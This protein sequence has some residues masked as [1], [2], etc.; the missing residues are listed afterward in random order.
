MMHR[1][2]SRVGL[3]PFTLAC[4]LALPFAAAAASGADFGNGSIVERGTFIRESMQALGVAV[5][6]RAPGEYRIPYE[7]IPAPMLPYIQAAEDAKALD[8]FGKDLRLAYPIT[9]GEALRFLVELLQV[10]SAQDV[11]RFRDVREGTMEERA[12][13]VAIGKA[14]MQPLRSNYFGLERQLTPAEARTLVNRASGEGGGGVPAGEE[15]EDASIPTI[16][17]ELRGKGAESTGNIPNAKVLDAVWQIVRS[18]YLYE[19]KIDEDDAMY[20]SIEAVVRSLGDPYSSFMRPKT[21]RQFQTQIDGEV[22]GIGAQVE[23]REGILTIVTPLEGSPAQKAGL[24]PNDQ[25]LSVDGV[26]IEDLDFLDAVE[27]VRGPRG[28]KVTLT[29]SR[30]GVHF[31]VT[32]LRDT[33]KVPEIAVS[34][35]GTVAVVRLMQFGKLTDTELRGLLTDIQ[36]KRPTGIVLDLRNNP[37]GLLHAANTVVSNF[38]PK[39]SDVAIIRARDGESVDRTSEEPTIRTDVPLVVLVNEG[40]ASASEIVAGALQDHD[41]ATIVGTKSFGKGTVQEV[42]EFVD[43]SSLKLTIAEWFTPKDRK[44][45]GIGVEPDVEVRYDPDRDVQLLRAIDLLR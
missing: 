27:K 22:S 9:R 18:D 29:I 23:E 15:G 41:R 7:R 39:G 25:I 14:W 11:G 16:R 6:E 1:F 28:S 34:W 4:M 19:E 30:N 36:A 8:A 45:D 33:V 32:V 35:Q 2:L 3:L 12:V 44:I 24:K 38:L 5:V 21:S 37:G 13:Q 42:L 10:K 20:D 40:S 26:S 43:G 31:D 17:I